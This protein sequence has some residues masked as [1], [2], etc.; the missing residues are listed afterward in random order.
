MNRQ[1]RA[2]VLILLAVIVASLAWWTWPRGDATKNAT[3]G[4]RTSVSKAQ[5]NVSQVEAPKLAPVTL[6]ANSDPSTEN[7]TDKN[8]TPIADNELGTI[9]FGVVPFQ[10]SGNTKKFSLKSGR[11]LEVRVTLLRDGSVGYNVSLVGPD[12]SGYFKSTLASHKPG[13]PFFTKLSNGETVSITAAVAPDPSDLGLLDLGEVDLHGGIKKIVTLLSGHTMTIFVDMDN[14]GRPILHEIV[15]YDNGT[16]KNA[17]GGLQ[18]GRP[19]TQELH[20]E[21][22]QF[23]PV[24]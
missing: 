21:A 13:V 4:E 1:S 24:F 2:T 8:G 6:A 7:T 12:P 19:F 18:P 22:V 20:N 11:T 3:V 9:D 14:D 23:T 15:V 17:Q 16:Q 5:T 10:S